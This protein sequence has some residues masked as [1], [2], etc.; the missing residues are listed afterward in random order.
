MNIPVSSTTISGSTVAGAQLAEGDQLQVKLILQLP[1]LLSQ[2]CDVKLTNE[3][4]KP[5]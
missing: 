5:T 2:I 4:T 3:N 1:S